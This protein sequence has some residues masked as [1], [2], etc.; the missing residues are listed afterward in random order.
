MACVLVY[1]DNQIWLVKIIIAHMFL[2]SP[3]EI[4]TYVQMQDSI[5]SLHKVFSCLF[6]TGKLENMS[7]K[8]MTK[9]YIIF[10]Y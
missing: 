7:E 1:E 5:W 10:R 6:L 8:K 9:S 2:V 4:F 3:G